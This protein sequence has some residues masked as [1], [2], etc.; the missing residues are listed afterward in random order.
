MILIL[1]ARTGLTSKKVFVTRAGKT[2]QQTVYVRSGEKKDKEKDKKLKSKIIEGMDVKI[3][4]SSEIGTVESVSGN[5]A[6]V[7]FGGTTSEIIKVENLR[8]TKR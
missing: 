7:N 8:E 5:K 4:G 1:K 6:V 3:L 2:F